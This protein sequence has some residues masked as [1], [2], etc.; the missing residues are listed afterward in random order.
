MTWA[1]I[2]HVANDWLAVPLSVWCLGLLVSYWKRPGRLGALWVGTVFALGLLTKSY[3]L[4]VA[5]L[6]IL[7]CALRKR[8]MDTLIVAG[9]VAGAAGPWYLRNLLCYGTISGMQEARAGI[10]LGAVIR[11]LPS[12][13]WARV[14]WASFR[15]AL[16]TGNNSF[17]SFSSVTLSLIGIC[18]LAGLVLWARSRHESFEWIVCAY[19][20]LYLAALVYIAAASWIYTQGES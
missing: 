13:D 6:A 20:M 11:A 12:I 8:W 4:A 9:I 16:W 18:G 2:A 14:A 17:T 19:G 1:T 5:P 3:F 10:G 7:V 15:A